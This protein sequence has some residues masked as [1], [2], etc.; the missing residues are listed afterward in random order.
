MSFDADVI[1]VGGGLAGL[2][3][4]ITANREGL[5][6]LILERG[7]YSGAKNVSGGRM[8]VHALK[9]LV[10]LEEAPLEKPIVRETYEITCGEKRLT[11]SFYD[12]NTRNSYSVLRAKFDPWLAKKAEEEGVLVMYETLVHDAVRENQGITVRTSRGD[13]RAKLVIEA[14]GVTA[15][16][17]RYLGLR[18]LSPDSLML[19]VKEVI[20]PDSVPEE[21]E[22]RV[23]VGY[24]NGLLGGGFMYVNKDTLSIGATVKVNSLQKE[25][26][27]AR[28]IVEDLRT[29]L[30]VEGEILEYSAH[31]IPYYGYTKLPPLTAPNLLVTGDA[32]GFLIN[33][34]FV[35][36]GMDLAI[37]SGIVAGRAA[38]K[39][40][41]LGDPSNTKIYEDMLQES[42]VM[43]DL[44]T[45]S[46]A[47]QL[48]NNERLFKV[49]PEL[50]CRVLSRMFTVE[51]ERKTLMTVF[52]EEVKRDGLTL[53]Q[54]V[55]DLTKVM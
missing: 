1:V 51:G 45:A 52:Q 7:E 36:R 12:P 30:G 23:L 22:A 15:G 38:K 43:K 39:I 55:R 41:D 16:V 54:V 47:F 37:G 3:A 44:K 8:Y 24:L 40:L 32:A 48:M 50:F 21:G 9:S 46:R 29:K 4:G 49:Y 28:D 33:D 11:F 25:R 35:I 18:S 5:S 14:D 26:V 13:L 34:G 53:T 2:S 31:L 17:S 42:F 19:G 10:N 20:K 6:T 27:L